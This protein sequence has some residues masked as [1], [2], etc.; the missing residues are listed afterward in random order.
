MKPQPA[1]GTGAK[2]LLG[3]LGLVVVVVIGSVM[4]GGN[5]GSNYKP[6][7]GVSDTDASFL[8]AIHGHG[9][10]N[11]GGDPALIRLGR[12]ICTELA[13]G[14]SIDGIAEHWGLTS[15]RMSTD[16]ARFFTRTAAA[17]YC[18]EYL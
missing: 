3:L 15:E 8:K 10:T 18:P 16:S 7:A 12:S 9:I 4:F 14:Q 6:P 2:V 13:S 11:D 5:S 17:A 1:M